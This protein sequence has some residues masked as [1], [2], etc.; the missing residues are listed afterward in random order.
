ME[1][2]NGIVSPGHDTTHALLNPQQ[3]WVPAD[4]PTDI[5][6]WIEGCFM[7]PYPKLGS[8]RY[9]GFQETENQFSL[10]T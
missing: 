9:C 1:D 2:E 7:S 3:L 6:A 10:R 4:Q 8:Y 5:T